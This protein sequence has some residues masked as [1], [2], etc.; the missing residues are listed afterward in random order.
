ME[1]FW[2]WVALGLAYLAL[3]IYAGAA[4]HW[5]SLPHELTQAGEMLSGILA[6]LG[7]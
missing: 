2:L 7:R 4:G 1:A 6:R 5:R 3:G